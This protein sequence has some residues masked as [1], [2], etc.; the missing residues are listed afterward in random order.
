[1][2]GLSLVGHLRSGETSRLGSMD[3]V[4]ERDHVR[5]AWWQE[6]QDKVADMSWCRVAAHKWSLHAGFVVVHHKTVGSRGVGVS[7]Q[8]KVY[9]G[10]FVICMVGLRDTG[11]ILV[12]APGMPYVQFEGV[13]YMPM[14]A[15]SR[16]YKLRSRDGGYPKYLDV[17]VSSEC[18]VR[19]V[20][21]SSIL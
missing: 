21:G 4:A 6:K 19:V 7:Y 5:A 15:C 9:F 12:Q 20:V 10:M 11:I 18:S 8:R 16:A 3:L 1:M 2:K 13:L 14:G 17:V